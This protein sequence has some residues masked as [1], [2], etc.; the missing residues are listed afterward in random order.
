MGF[1][2]EVYS[3]NPTRMP[4]ANKPADKIFQISCIFKRGEEDYESYLLTLGDPDDGIFDEDI[5]IWTFSSEA[6]L[7]EGFTEI[8]IEKNPQIISGYNIFGFDIPYMIQRAKSNFS[9]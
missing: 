9:Y 7:L 2:I 4:D 3:S 1:D 8:I 5:E 6:Q